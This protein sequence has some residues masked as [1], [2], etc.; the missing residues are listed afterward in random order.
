MAY[1]PTPDGGKVVLAVA[2]GASSLAAPFLR[3]ESKVSAP[4]VEHRQRGDDDEHEERLATRIGSRG[5]SGLCEL[6]KSKEAEERRVVDDGA[7]RRGASSARLA[8]GPRAPRVA[9]ARVIDDARAEGGRR[10]HDEHEVQDRVAV[11]TRPAKREDVPG[12]SARRASAPRP[13]RT[14][15]PARASRRRRS[16]RRARR[17]RTA[18][19]R[20]AGRARRTPRDT[21][22]ARDR[23]SRV[24]RLASR[25]M[26]RT[27]AIAV[28]AIIRR[29][30]SGIGSG[31]RE[32][33]REHLV[34]ALA[35]TSR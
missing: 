24:G 4:T 5:G 15:L 25:A 30:T 26:R 11:V 34:A 35:P 18:G 32:E 20:R 2:A 17:R 14:K 23:R 33:Q 22:T 16:R 7:P 31:G 21:R 6:T 8:S 3:T 12:R 13:R 9:R 1:A 19:A 10:H 27:W 28:S 29:S